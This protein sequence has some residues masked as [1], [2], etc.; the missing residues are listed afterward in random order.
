MTFHDLEIDGHPSYGVEGLV[1]HNCHSLSKQGW[2]V[3]L[4]TLEEPPDYLYFGL[5]TTELQKVPETIVQRCY[6]VALRPVPAPELGDLIDAIAGLEGWTIH[7]Q[8]RTLVLQAAAGSPRKALAGLQAVQGADPA[9]AAR[10]LSLIGAGEPLLD[11]CRQLV[12]GG[13]TWSAVQ[14]LLVRIEDDQ[15]EKAS[16]MAAGYVVSTL[17]RAENEAAAK[18]AWTLLDALTFPSATYDSRAQFVAAVGRIFFA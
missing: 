11:L 18:R 8:A 14:K 12:R 2:Q 6:H 15:W 1:A 4:K 9:E 5:C 16:G 3:L 7:P 13:A 10:V 17:L